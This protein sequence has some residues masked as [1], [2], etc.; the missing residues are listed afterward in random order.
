MVSETGQR[1]CCPGCRAPIYVPPLGKVVASRP[2]PDARPVNDSFWLI[3]AVGAAAALVLASGTWWLGQRHEHAKAADRANQEVAARVAA[4]RVALSQQRWDEAA[5]L[6]QTALAT[7]NATRLED[8]QAL[9]TDLRRQQAAGVLRAAESALARR[10]VAKTL[11]LLQSYLDDPY[12]AEHDKADYLKKQLELATSDAEAAARLR[13]L[14]D[15]ALVD[16]AQT[17]TLADLR[18]FE[19]PD[20]RAI[21]LDKLRCGLGTEIRKREEERTNRAR[22]I[23]TTPVFGEFQE[24][25]ALS[26]RRLLART[27]GG[28]IDH[29][30][31]ARF[32]AEVQINGAAEQQR[33]QKE[34]STRPLDYEE[35]EKL[36]RLRA[37]FKERFRAYK[38]FDNRDREMFDEAVDQEVNQFLQD[39]Q[40]GSAADGTQ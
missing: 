24:F 23:Q 3:W 26:R 6:L 5:G 32:F 38:D 28:E 15:V 25:V 8:A 17:G 39:L 12:G 36:A 35:A 40:G 10:D 13:L 31:L 30:L 1:K 37:N 16:F 14:T 9:W 29:R 20:V 27:G 22:R 34:L 21:H 4:A 19:H 2:R 7:E 18:D 33:I 11:S